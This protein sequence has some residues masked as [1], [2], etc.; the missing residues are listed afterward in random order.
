MGVADGVDAA[1][2]EGADGVVGVADGV[3]VVT[4]GSADGW[5]S[6]AVVGALTEEAIDVAATAELSVSSEPVKTRHTPMDIGAIH[7]RPLPLI[8]ILTGYTCFS[9]GLEEAVMRRGIE[10]GSLGIANAANGMA[11]TIGARSGRKHSPGVV[12]ANELNGTSGNV[13]AGSWE[14]TSDGDFTSG[15]LQV[16]KRAEDVGTSMF[17]TFV[18]EGAELVLRIWSGAGGGMEVVHRWRN[19]SRDIST[20]EDAPEFDNCRRLDTSWSAV[21]CAQVGVFDLP[22]PAVVRGRRDRLLP[23]VAFRRLL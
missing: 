14:R 16:L 8:L 6:G 18:T 22:R 9:R 3:D 23:A 20:A 10:D 7:R 19:G 1:E 11:E 13:D 17:F 5:L 21:A 12:T 2:G 4:L 15:M